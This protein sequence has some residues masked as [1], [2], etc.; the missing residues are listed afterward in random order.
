MRG[1]PGTGP[2]HAVGTGSSLRARFTFTEPERSGT[3]GS[4]GRPPAG[5]A[6]PHQVEV[7]GLGVG[8]GDHR[9]APIRVPSS[10]STPAARPHAA[11]HPPPRPWVRLGLLPVDATSDD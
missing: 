7:G 6:L 3:G 9:P 8:A 5:G 10:S 11:V 2:S 4:S 1:S